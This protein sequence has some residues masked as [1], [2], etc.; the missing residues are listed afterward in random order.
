MGNIEQVKCNTQN[1]F[2]MLIFL[3]Y[4]RMW[5]IDVKRFWEVDNSGIEKIS[6]MK[7][8]DKIVLDTMVIDTEFLF[9]RKKM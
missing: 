4:I 9:L 8:E 7:G 6:L 5:T 3:Q 1:I 2:P